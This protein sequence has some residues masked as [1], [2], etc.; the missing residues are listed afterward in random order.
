[1]FRKTRIHLPPNNVMEPNSLARACLT[2]ISKDGKLLTEGTIIIAIEPSNKAKLLSC[3]G[4]LISEGELSQQ[5]SDALERATGL[6]SCISARTVSQNRPFYQRWT[7][8]LFA[9]MT[10]QTALLISMVINGP[11][12]HIQISPEVPVLSGPQDQGG[13][14]PLYTRLQNSIQ[15]GAPISEADFAQFPDYLQKA[16]IEAGM[17]VG[18]RGNS[19]PKMTNLQQMPAPRTG[20]RSITIVK[21]D[22]AKP[23]PASSFPGEDAYGISNLP[24]P[25]TTASTGNLKIPMPGGND[26]RSRNDAKKF[27]LGEFPS[28]IDEKSISR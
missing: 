14:S 22:G 25:N 1:M 21:A 26:F 9:L 23:D 19:A 18:R 6:P 13:N 16:I 7:F 20:S 28:D 2:P 4:Q 3:Q 10:L 15:S 12:R 24:P 8:Y 11:L 5:T 17:N 27:G